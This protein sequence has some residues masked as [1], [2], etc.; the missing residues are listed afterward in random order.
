MLNIVKSHNGKI[1]R[2]TLGKHSTL[3]SFAVFPVA[4]SKILKAFGREKIGLNRL[5]E[6][7]YSDCV[8]GLECFLKLD[9]IFQDLVGVSPLAK[10]TIAATG[11]AS[12]EK[13]AGKMPKDL[14]HLEAYR[15][16]RCEVFNTGSQQAALYDIN[17]SYP[18][19]FIECQ[20][21]EE[22][23]HIEVTTND[24][25]GPFF[26]ELDDEILLF[27]S[28]HFYSWVYKSNLDR[29][30]LPYLERTKIKVLSRRKIDTLWLTDV[31]ELMK[32][33]YD[34]KLQAK[35]QND[36]GVE[37]ACKFLLNSTYGRIGL[38]GESERAR[39]VDHKLDGDDIAHWKIGKRWLVF[40]TIQ[41]EPRSNFPFA[42]FITDNARARLFQAFKRNPVLY[43]DTDSCF[44][45]PKTAFSETI[46]STL[47]DWNH[48]GTKRF[49][50]R[51]VK[52]YEWGDEHK[53]K[54]MSKDGKP[55]KQWTLKTFAQ[56][57]TVQEV[58]KERRT[59]LRKRVILPDGNTLPVTVNY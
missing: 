58:T 48:K 11:F 53:T 52:D 34:R 2:C 20:T 38:R 54:G 33:V 23:F 25:H 39:I 42:A 24:W 44:T 19:S 5:S 45:R 27:P 31:A 43:G 13:V 7:N 47:G 16:G 30:I 15:G 36:F 55:F 10:G 18:T 3:N 51:S 35:Q 50:A 4:L 12:A 14:E 21:M 56:G 41:Q 37:E 26:D 49:C 17:S 57:K 6:R 8:D 22:L 46:G 40:E 32:T 28:G 1:I 9:A 59:T 29:Y